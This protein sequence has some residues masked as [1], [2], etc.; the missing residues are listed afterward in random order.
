MS[1]IQVSF[2]SSALKAYEKGPIYD[3]NAADTRASPTIVTLSCFKLI[4]F[5]AHLLFSS[6]SPFTSLFARSN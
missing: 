5:R 6:A 4:T 3:T 2:H 1:S